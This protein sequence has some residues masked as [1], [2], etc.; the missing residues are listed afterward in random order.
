MT[1]HRRILVDDRAVQVHVDGEE[2]VT[3]DG[4]RIPAS[5]AHYLP[6]VQPTKIIATHL[7]YRSRVEEFMT[8]F[9]PAPP[10]FHKPTTSLNA[11][12]GDVV[13]PRRCKYLNY[14]GEIAIVIGKKAFDISPDEA[15]D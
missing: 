12:L 1:E 4:V 3:P 11:H 14:E 15:A 10:Y 2:L 13:R 6:P 5:E 9:P 8:E 7:T